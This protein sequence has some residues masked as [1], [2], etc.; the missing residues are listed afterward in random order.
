M[1]V[2]KY[3]I[4]IKV[5][6]L[7]SYTKAAEQLNYTQSG[8]SHAISA[9]EEEFGFPLLIRSRSGVRLTPDGERVLPAIRGI[10][11]STE[12]LNQIVSAVKGLNAGTVRVG[13]FTSV[14]VHWLPGMIKQFQRDYPNVDF[15]LLNG[16]YH[17]IEQWLA[18]GSID[19]GFVNLPMQGDCPCI[20]LGEDR[21]LA[22]LPKD[23]RLANRERFPLEELEKE[24]FIGLLE[25]SDHDARRV[26][27]Q[28]G[29]KPNIKFTT[30]DDYAIIAMVENGLGI[31]IMPELLLRGRTD[32]VCVMEL[33]T[34]MTRS[35][36]LAVPQTAK[37]T[38]AVQRFAQ[39]VQRYLG[40]AE[41][42]L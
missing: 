32:N 21:L 36:A 2:S 27:E 28:A 13:A 1:A 40:L 31:S 26:M 33:S 37:N 10:V 15:Q 8:V 19:L 29:V 7:Q 3:E 11:N 20:P 34:P 25:S 42:T 4:F 14:A 23:H 9:M 6:E 22:V 17:D 39:Y 5:V 35:L 12:Q 16:D 24:P 41:D 30:K 38:P 18:S